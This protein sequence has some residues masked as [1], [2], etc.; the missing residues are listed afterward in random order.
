MC[1]NGLCVKKHTLHVNSNNLFGSSQYVG[2]HLFVS[3]L[4]ISLIFGIVIFIV[5]VPCGS[6]TFSLDQGRIAP[7]PLSMHVVRGDYLECLV[8]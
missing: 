2:Y 8:M 6:G 1:W 3:I 5:T 7:L 4:C